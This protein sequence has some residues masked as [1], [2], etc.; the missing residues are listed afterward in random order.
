MGKWLSLDCLRVFVFH[1]VNQHLAR[2]CVFQ[3]NSIEEFR[4]TTFAATAAAATTDDDDLFVSV[5]DLVF[6]NRVPHGNCT[7]FFV[8]VQ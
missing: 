8:I 4:I 3:I 6:V 5:F 2:N 1:F 7:Q